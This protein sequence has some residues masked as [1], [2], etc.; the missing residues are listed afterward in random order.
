VR[1][2]FTKVGLGDNFTR[3]MRF[4]PENIK[5]WLV[6][7]KKTELPGGSLPGISS[8]KITNFCDDERRE[9]GDYESL[10]VT[11]MKEREKDEFA[12]SIAY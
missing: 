5:K 10:N 7:E 12:P 1:F 3:F 4:P 8:L 6:G 11:W 2:L 9:G